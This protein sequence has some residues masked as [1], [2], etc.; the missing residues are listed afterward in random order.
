MLKN[1]LATALNNLLK[2]KL[3]SFINIAGLSIGLAAC[4]LIALYVQMESSY[5][6]HWSN[7]DRLYRVNTSI[8][9]TGGDPR[10]SG[11]TSLLAL[12]ALKT[13]F[14][15]EIEYASRVRGTNKE[16]YVGE[17]R[18]EDVVVNVDPD[19]VNMLD[20][21]VLAG[22]LARTLSDPR[23]I[24]LSATQAAI[25][26][27]TANAVGQEL[28]IV[29]A[30]NQAQSVREN[31]QV[32]AVYRVPGPT[33]IDLPAMAMLDEATFDLFTF[34]NWVTLDFTTYVQMKSGIDKQAL[35]SRLEDFTNTYVT[36]PRID[37]GP[38]GRVSDRVSFDFQNLA[39]V[40]LDDA[41]T[42]TISDGDKTM[43]MAFAAIAVLVLLIGCLNFT[44]LSTARA[45]QRAKEVALRKTVGAGRGQLIVQFLGE[46]FLVVVPAIALSLVLVE[47]MLPFF[48]SLVNRNL[49]V[50]YAVPSTWLALLLLAV[51]V[52][53]TGGVYPALV[54]S[55]FRPA[56]TLK[57]TAQ[58][59]S[60]SSIGLRSALVV[61]QFSISI[62]LII[63]TAVIYLQVEYSARRDPGFDGE[64]VLV[65]DNLNRRADVSAVKNTLKQ[66]IAALTSVEA[67][68][69]SGHQPTQT[70]GYVTMTMLHTLEGGSGT[71]QAIPTMSVDYD[72][73][74]TY[75][76][77]FVAGRNYDA[78]RDQPTPMF[79]GGYQSPSGNSESN[80]VIN[81]STA[82]LLGFAN[83]QD[84]LGRRLVNTRGFN[85]ALHNFTITGVVA[86]TQFFS[87]RT[88][89][90]PEIY[91]LSPQ[92]MSDV[93]SVRYSGNPQQVLGEIEPVWQ[94][95]TGGAELSTA[96]VEQKMAGEFAQERIEARM[97]VSFAVLAIIIACLGLYGS[98]AFAVDRRTKE[99]GIRKVMGAEVRE[100]VTLL[101]WQFS[102]PVLLANVIAWPVA[103][104]AMLRWLQRFPYQIDSVVLVPL[105]ILA[106]ALALS[107]AWL[108]VAGNTVR[109][110]TTKPVLALRYE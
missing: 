72:F 51:V 34:G 82:R 40:Y 33:V 47:L 70:L 100:I 53:L 38:D 107:I 10:R 48:E 69:L 103:L 35:S 30:I 56:T 7:G 87:L 76:I 84:A 79:Q 49:E 66:E 98:A 92:F 25:Y 75:R 36:L 91:V 50:P 104:W 20:F 88:A 85:A 94:R 81:A 101:L 21:D 29:R 108:T 65:L 22:D 54:L 57:G 45:T 52:G 71:P 109:V 13:Y 17:Q 99:I 26:F 102:K 73:F 68:S 86:D 96:L 41:I 97:L 18:Y 95:V 44:I 9:M 64:N 93:L 12:N 58:A 28:T 46:S 14:P 27:G 43:V 15:D 61:F 106:G 8:D 2:N 63:A 4:L 3:F 90:R 89:P 110:A 67:V 31:F 19:I 16:L 23:S 42:D 78:A 62:A 24:A 59:E 55:M 77:A 11:W 37:L 83:P 6:K 5:D 80:V 60:R 39:A 32:G 74:D 105:C 1:Y